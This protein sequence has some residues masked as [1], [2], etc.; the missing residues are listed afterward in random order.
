MI[1]SI[2]ISLGQGAVHNGIGEEGQYQQHRQE[3]NGDGLLRLLQE[4]ITMRRF[5]AS[6]LTVLYIVI[7]ESFQ[8]IVMMDSHWQRWLFLN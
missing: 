8:F 2:N 5:T 3:H 7:R 6:Y 4:K 1:R